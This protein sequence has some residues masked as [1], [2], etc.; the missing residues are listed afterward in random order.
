MNP[1]SAAAI[2]A[3]PVG[4]M[5]AP[6][7]WSLFPQPPEFG[8]RFALPHGQAARVSPAQKLVI[9]PLS[10]Q[11]P[12]ISQT[13]GRTVSSSVGGTGA[14]FRFVKSID[15]EPAGKSPTIQQR[16]PPATLSSSGAGNVPS[17]AAPIQY[18][19]VT[20]TGGIR[21]NVW[22]GAKSVSLLT[23]EADAVASSTRPLVGS[24]PSV[25]AQIPTRPIV[26]FGGPE[27]GPV[28]V[29]HAVWIELITV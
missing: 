7:G 15:P 23:T 20:Y 21:S 12:R 17:D 2:E 26:P 27:P 13:P 1:R 22:P 6:C 14:A 11:S 19:P 9:V 28:G 29:P 24:P 4:V 5:R 16:P 3:V 10:L 25:S 8:G 18:W